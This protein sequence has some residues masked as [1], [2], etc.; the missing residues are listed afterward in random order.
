MIIA[1]RLQTCR[2]Q[3]E[4]LRGGQ[5]RMFAS[6]RC[7]VLEALSPIGSH[8]LRPNTATHALQVDQG[9]DDAESPLVADLPL[10]Q[11]AI[12]AMDRAERQATYCQVRALG[13]MVEVWAAIS[14]SVSPQLALC[15]CRLLHPKKTRPSI[16]PLNPSNPIRT[17]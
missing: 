13:S 3:V 15:F 1:S 5:Y 10:T 6:R 14:W 2:L 9:S 8:S 11:A 17:A 4:R 12:D 16:F 7:V